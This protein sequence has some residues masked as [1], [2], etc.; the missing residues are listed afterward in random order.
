METEIEK[1]LK[2][3]SQGTSQPC[4]GETGVFQPS[5]PTWQAERLTCP[6]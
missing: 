2:G 3:P 6:A 4:T 1:T 5:S